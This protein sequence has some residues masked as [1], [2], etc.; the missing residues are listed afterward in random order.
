MES[1]KNVRIYIQGRGE[2]PGDGQTT[3]SGNSE[4]IAWF[5]I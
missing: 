1:D 2:K 5:K 4:G 3:N